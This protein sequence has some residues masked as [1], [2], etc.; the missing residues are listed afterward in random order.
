MKIPAKEL[1]LCALFA[2]LNAVLSQISIPV[3]PVP[4][5]L[6][7]LSTFTA[8]GLLGARYGALSQLVFVLLGAVGL[9]VF[10][11]F[12]GGLMRVIG[13]TG[14]YILAYIGSAFIT[15]FIIEK[16]GKRTVGV[17][18]AAIYSGWVVTYLFGTLWYSYITHTGFTAALLVCV[19]PFLPG[20]CL[21]TCFSIFFIKKLNPV[22][23][24]N[25]R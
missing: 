11:G 21:K 18:A 25:S 10:S 22:L 15:G 8:A 2:A 19:V 13:P 6:A 4:I 14:G 9:P 16:S 20:D 24:L 23:S 5:N 12:N 17:L 7:H 3:G 1:T